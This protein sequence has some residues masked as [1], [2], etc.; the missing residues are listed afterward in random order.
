MPPDFI[1]SKNN[2]AIAYW[3]TIKERIPAFQQAYEDGNQF[4]VNKNP[5]KAAERF[6]AAHITAQ[7]T[8]AEII[9]LIKN[10]NDD[11]YNNFS[12]INKQREYKKLNANGT[13][14]VLTKERL[15]AFKAVLYVHS[16]LAYVTLRNLV[17]IYKFMWSKIEELAEPYKSKPTKLE[18][19][20][21]KPPLNANINPSGVLDANTRQEYNNKV[22]LA[23]NKARDRT[24]KWIQNNTTYED[25][26]YLNIPR[27]VDEYLKAKGIRDPKTP[28]LV[29]VNPSEFADKT[30][31]GGK[32]L[33]G[34]GSVVGNVANATGAVV[35]GIGSAG[36]TV[37]SAPGKVVNA[38]AGF[39]KP[40]PLP[41]Q[42]RD[43]RP[44]QPKAAPKPKAAPGPAPAA[45][46]P[47]APA[48]ADPV[49]QPIKVTTPPQSPGKPRKTSLA[50]AAV[51]V[52]EQ[53]RTLRSAST[54]PTASAGTSA[55]TSGATTP[56]GYDTEDELLA[57]YTLPLYETTALKPSVG[58]EALMKDIEAFRALTPKYIAAHN[59]YYTQQ[60]VAMQAEAQYV[61]GKTE[62]QALEN[63][64]EHLSEPSRAGA[65]VAE[66]AK[67][68]A[69]IATMQTKLAAWKDLW[70]KAK[71]KQ[72]EA[73]DAL[74]KVME[75]RRQLG[76]PVGMSLHQIQKEP[77]FDEYAVI[78]Q[79]ID[80]DVD[81]AT[82]M[83]DK[84]VEGVEKLETG[85]NHAVHERHLLANLVKA[86]VTELKNANAEIVQHKARIAELEEQIQKDLEER[87]RT[88]NNPQ[89]AQ[90][91][92]TK[93]DTLVVL[94]TS[95]LQVKSR[96]DILLKQIS[97]MF[98]K[99]EEMY[100]IVERTNSAVDNMDTEDP[101]LVNRKDLAG[102]AKQAEQLRVD[103]ESTSG[104]VD[105][106]VQSLFDL[107]KRVSYPNQV[108]KPT[109][110][111][112]VNRLPKPA[113][114]QDA[115]AVRGLVQ[116]AVQNAK[117]A[118]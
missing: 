40:A 39:N 108:I 47:A 32:I 19:W 95:L 99:I 85:V 13:S 106:T 42:F 22:T 62:I 69:Q 28:A 48:V 118:P 79:T 74:L 34:L 116:N 73:G 84:L 88:P 57:S 14:E 103:L 55:A 44:I 25:F 9:I 72:V 37:L 105:E 63:A 70:V 11:I 100:A 5:D 53:G 59:A 45:P 35:Q 46:A 117:S 56:G 29:T 89:L 64:K 3:K 31:L 91:I 98:T 76:K 50:E 52:L 38:V 15:A 97:V 30:S 75:E 83:L 94:S 7:A 4:L 81:K 24:A 12:T 21:K 68:D 10:Y 6:E 66:L 71:A 86:H 77:G 18:D 93:V 26:E 67:V 90:A 102:L 107:L 82:T 41:D 23:S 49:A 16:Y 111:N 113:S 65:N 112:T 61:S 60:Q 80:A 33:G 51:Q 115:A 20:T 96:F 8:A 36:G 101:T 109:P 104:G 92:Q 43:T 54:S 27:D 110:Q 17:D 78:N 58:G 114:V 1:R 87:M 2:I